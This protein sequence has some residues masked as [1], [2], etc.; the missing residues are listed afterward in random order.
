MILS[1]SLLLSSFGSYENL[2]AKKVP[3]RSAISVPE[4]AEKSEASIKFVD[5]AE[6]QNRLRKLEENSRK[7]RTKEYI[8]MKTEI[9]ENVV[10]H[11]LSAEANTNCYVKLDA[12]NYKFYSTHA[13]DGPIE[14]A[15]VS[16]LSAGE[17]NVKFQSRINSDKT[18]EIVEKQY[19]GPDK[20]KRIIVHEQ[21][22]EY[23]EITDKSRK[24]QTPSNEGASTVENFI[25]RHTV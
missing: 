16:L 20:W 6:V 3:F 5:A 8:E 17:E 18:I 14:A 19:L 9:A 12:E 13:N 25:F 22:R 1:I 7:C 10:A 21:P 23:K 2:E 24:K 15:I 4:R 11:L